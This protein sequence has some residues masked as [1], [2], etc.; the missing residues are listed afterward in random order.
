MSVLALIV[1][2]TEATEIDRPGH[3]RSDDHCSVAS[4]LDP[5]RGDGT[6]GRLMPIM[7]MPLAAII[8]L[9]C[10]PL[11]VL[12][13]LSSPR[14]PDTW[15]RCPQVSGPQQLDFTEV[16]DTWTPWRLPR[17]L[18]DMRACAYVSVTYI[19][20]HSVQVS[21]NIGISNV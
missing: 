4:S 19:S 8:V 16:S 14:C 7:V 13:S 10:T 20:V 5:D 3:H 2:M 6:N 15:S 18:G 1:S 17:C 12:S 21:G 11:V 9:I